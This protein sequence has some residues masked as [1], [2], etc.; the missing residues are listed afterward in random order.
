MLLRPGKTRQAWSQKST[1]KI[2]I[3]GKAY[4][5]LFLVYSALS[6]TAPMKELCCTLLSIVLSSKVYCALQVLRLQVHCAINWT[7]LSR[8]CALNCTALACVECA[9][10]FCVLICSGLSSILYFQVYSTVLCSQ[11]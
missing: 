2:C 3:L 8:Y 11:V 10:V 1:V 9:Q 4:E 5:L 7:T 6:C